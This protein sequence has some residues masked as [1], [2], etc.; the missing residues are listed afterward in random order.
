M[1][2]NTISDCYAI[3]G[4]NHSIAF[5]TKMLRP[6]N[7]SARYVEMP[8]LACLTM[9]CSHGSFL[10]SIV[11]PDG[12]GIFVTGGL[13][14]DWPVKAQ[15]EFVYKNGTVKQGPDLSKH[16]SFH[17]M[18]KINETTLYMIGGFNRKITVT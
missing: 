15:T 10:F 12:E 14:F 1:T 16:M 6:R 13:P 11:T 2:N 3:N 18:V 8:T 17:C 5:L 4:Q 7:G 9:A